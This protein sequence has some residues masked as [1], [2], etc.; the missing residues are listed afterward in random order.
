MNA[1]SEAELNARRRSRMRQRPNRR[2]KPQR[3]VLVDLRPL[4]PGA[5]RGEALAVALVVDAAD[6][7]LLPTDAIT[8]E[9]RRLDS[10]QELLLAELGRRGLDSKCPRLPQLADRDRRQLDGGTAQ[11]SYR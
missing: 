6:V 9:G 2:D 3:S 10:P 1:I 4:A 5:A 7:W 8:I 11:G